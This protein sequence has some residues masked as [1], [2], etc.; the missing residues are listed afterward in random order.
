MSEESAEAGGVARRTVLR[1]GAVGGA[2]VA[3][4]AAH[5][6]GVPFLA[7]SGLLSA[8]GAFAATSIALGD[9]KLFTSRTS[10]RAR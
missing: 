10:R 1:L 6:L 5:G 2:G 9:L 8:D 4:T 3:L 7:Q